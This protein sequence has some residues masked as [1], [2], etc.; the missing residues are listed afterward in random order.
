MQVFQ[1]G[2]EGVATCPLMGQALLGFIEQCGQRIATAS[3]MSGEL[4]Q[5][6]DDGRQFSSACQQARSGQARFVEQG[7]Q[8][9][10]AGVVGVGVGRQ[11]GNGRGQ[12]VDRVAVVRGL[13]GQRML[14]SSCF[15]AGFVKVADAMLAQGLV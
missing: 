5:F 15:V 13:L 9:L 8:Q 11:L 1:L 6:D 12:L 4:L 3:L 14:Q 7:R 2:G 10:G